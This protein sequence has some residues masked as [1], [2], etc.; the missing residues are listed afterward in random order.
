MLNEVLLLYPPGLSYITPP[1]GLAYLAAVLKK[2]NISVQILDASAEGLSFGQTMAVIKDAKPKIIGI[3]AR[4][5]DY[6]M[7]E[8]IIWVIKNEFPSASIVLGGPHPTIA[9]EEVLKSSLADYVVR[10][11]GE[12]TFLELCKFLLNGEKKNLSDI[13]GI[14]YRS[15]NGIVHNADR[16]FINNLDE[17]PLPSRDLL[18]VLKYRNYGQIVKRKPV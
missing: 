15:D 10:G 8:K 14:S 2:E 1:L 6:N 7:I 4:T 3:S 13:K 9:P 17:L 5:P 11:E 16:P 12:H 18:P